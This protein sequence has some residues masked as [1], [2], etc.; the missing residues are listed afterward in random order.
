[1]A[2]RTYTPTF[3]GNGR[4]VF[5]SKH[6]LNTHKREYLMRLVEELGHEREGDQKKMKHKNENKKWVLHTHM[7]TVCFGC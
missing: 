1:M 7:H 6:A 3:A 2:A 4:G 5:N